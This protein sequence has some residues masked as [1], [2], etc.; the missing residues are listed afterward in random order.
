M[1]Q[2]KPSSA[3]A[4]AAAV[5]AVVGGLLFLVVSALAV[6]AV[7]GS[8]EFVGEQIV[9]A[10]EYL[11]VAG[12]LLPGGILLFLHKPAGRTLTVVGSGIAILAIVVNFV[13][14]LMGA[15]AI[16]GDFRAGLLGGIALVVVPAVATMVLA[17]VK[18]TAM[19]CGIGVSPHSGRHPRL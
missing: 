5:F 10:V 11:L 19:W 16:D 9:G 6:I 18:P 1:T 13:L 8:D 4:I 14:N 7:F 15:A 2:P 3:T 12:T 17:L